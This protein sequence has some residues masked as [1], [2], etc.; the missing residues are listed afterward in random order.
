MI[1]KDQILYWLPV[2]YDAFIGRKG[3][4]V[5]GYTKSGTNWLCNMLRYYYGIKLPARYS[6]KQ[7]FFGSRI[8]HMHRFLPTNYFLKS[9]IYLVRDGRD[10]IVSRYFTMVNQESQ[11]LM[12]HDF[13]KYSGNKPTIEN[14]KE[15]LPDY[16]RFLIT[17]HKSTVDYK[18]HVDIAIN[19]GYFIIKYEELHT[20]TA[21]ALTKAVQFLTPENS[22]NKQL[23]NESVEYWSFEASKK[24]QK[25]DTGFFRKGGGQSGDWKNYFTRESADTF[26][27]YAGDVL[28]KLGYE[29]NNNWVNR[30]D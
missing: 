9:S 29:E 24:R 18:T 15:T 14:I 10:T 19:K 25:V 21:T 3:Y 7:G 23:I 26:N 8:Y 12:K 4:Y 5:I 6:V 27:E 17:Y 22:L 16:I 28:I 20:E 11:M 30:F 1:K 2:F 13:I